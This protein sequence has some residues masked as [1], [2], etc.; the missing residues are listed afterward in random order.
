MK[1]AIIALLLLFTLYA[2]MSLSRASVPSD[3]PVASA[4][5]SHEPCASLV[6]SAHPTSQKSA[7]PGL[8]FITVPASGSHA[9]PPALMKTGTAAASVPPEKSAAIRSRMLSLPLQF[10]ENRGQ[11]EA[12]Y[13]F[14]SR[15]HG[16]SVLLRSDEARIIFATSKGTLAAGLKFEGAN[17]KV[18]GVGL[19]PLPGKVNY[20]KGNDES[21]WLTAVPT[22]ARVKYEG[23]YQ[24]VDVV[25]YGNQRRLEYDFVVAAHA[26]PK[27]ICWNAKGVDA[28]KLS[29]EGNLIL[30]IGG[31]DMEI[32]KPVAYQT[33][34]GTRKP[35]EA[36]YQIS[37][38]Q[39][40]FALNSY[41]SNKE[42]VIDPIVQF[43]YSTFLGGQ[44][45]D[46][47]S[48]V[49]VDAQGRVYVAG[50]SMGSGAYPVFGG[51]SSGSFPIPNFKPPYVANVRNDG[52]IFATGT[53]NGTMHAADYGSKDAFVAILS[54]DL[55]SILYATYLGGDYFD[56]AT[57]LV[58]DG[59]GAMYV[60]G[61]TTSWN[62]PIRKAGPSLDPNLPAA[63]STIK[64]IIWGTTA[65]TGTNI[66]PMLDTSSGLQDGFVT[67]LLPTGVL[68]FSTFIGADLD[69]RVETIC[70]SDGAV[71]VAGT[72]L[73]P[74]FYGHTVLQPGSDQ[75]MFHLIVKK[76]VTKADGSVDVVTETTAAIAETEPAI[77]CVTMPGA[78]NALNIVNSVGYFTCDVTPK[79]P[80]TNAYQREYDLTVILNDATG[81]K[82]SLIGG[83]TVG[84]FPS[85]GV[86]VDVYAVSDYILI[87][88][89][90][91][92]VN[93][94]LPPYI[95]INNVDY[96]VN[97][98][99]VVLPNLA[100]TEWDG[101]AAVIRAGTYYESLGNVSVMETETYTAD[102]DG[103]SVNVQG[104]TY[105]VVSGSNT[106]GDTIYTVAIGT[107]VYN[108][109]PT[110]GSSP[111]VGTFQLSQPVKFPVYTASIEY[112]GSTE[113][114]K[115][116][117][118]VINGQGYQSYRVQIRL[119]SGVTDAF[120]LRVDQPTL[121][122][123]N[124]SINTADS[125]I[126]GGAGDDTIYSMAA[127]NSGVAFAGRSQDPTL[128]G[129]VASQFYYPMI[130]RVGGGQALLAVL[131]NAEGQATA[132]AMDRKFGGTYFA[133]TTPSQK[134][135]V[136]NPLQTYPQ[137]L[138]RSAPN[139]PSGSAYNGFVLK[140]DESVTNIS[141]STYLGGSK[142]DFVHGLA[143][144][145]AGYVYV[146]GETESIDFPTLGTALQPDGQAV[147]VSGT[148]AQMSSDRNHGNAFLSVLVP[149]GN[150][151]RY[152]TYFGG[153]ETEWGFGVAVSP[154]RNP[155][156]YVVGYTNSDDFPILSGS[157]APVISGTN[158]SQTYTTGF[159]T[160]FQDQ[161]V[162][163]KLDSITTDLPV[164]IAGQR[165]TYTVT[166]SNT[167]PTI[168]GQTA[169]T[170]D[171]QDARVSQ[172]L[173][174]NLV[175]VS[176][177]GANIDNFS[178]GSLDTTT[179]TVS[180]D[181]GPVL[182]GRQVSY[183]ITVL[184]TS[185]EVISTA[186]RVQAEYDVNSKNDAMSLQLIARPALSLSVPQ[187]VGSQNGTPAVFMV[188]RQGD[189]SQTLTVNYAVA[190]DAANGINYQKLPGTVATASGTTAT[191]VLP[192]GSA[193][194]S[195]VIAPYANIATTG[196][197]KVILTLLNGV[198]YELGSVM[199]G[200]A[201]SGTATILPVDPDKVKLTVPDP[202]A[203]KNSGE[204]A[205]FTVLRTG[206]LGQ[207][208]T[209]WY[210]LAGSAII[211]KDY[212]IIGDNGLPI[213]GTSGS[214]TIPANTTQ[215][216]ISI[217]PIPD[218]VSGQPLGNTTVTLVLSAT[219]TTPSVPPP[220]AYVLDLSGST[221][222]SA[223]ITD[224][225]PD[226]VDLAVIRSNASASGTSGIFRITRTG[227]ASNL[228]SAIAVHYTM[229][230]TAVSGSD[231]VALTGVATIPA[232]AASVDVEV[233]PI[234][235]P[236]ETADE[237]AIMVLSP[238]LNQ[239]VYTL[240][241][242]TTGTVTI[243]HFPGAVVTVTAPPQVPAIAADI[244]TTSGT[245][246]ISRSGST[247]AP[248]TVNY[249]MGGTANSGV[250]YV[251]SSGSATL[252]GTV[253][254]P[255][256]QANATVTL[257]PLRNGLSSG[258]E[259]AVLTVQPASA[260]EYL[261][262]SPSNAQVTINNG[263]G[264]VRPVVSLIAISND[265][266]LTSGS[267]VLV[268]RVTRTSGTSQAVSVNYNI[269]GS[270]VNGSD[271]QFLTGAVA[272]GANV[273]SADVVV[274]PI[275][276][277][278][279]QP[280]K[281][282]SIQ[283]AAG[284]G[285]DLGTATYGSG[286][287]DFPDKPE[288]SL[289]VLSST[290][291]NTSASGTDAV[292]FKITRTG[293]S[294]LP[295]AINYTMGGTAIAGDDYLALPGSITLPA[296][297]SSGTV[298]VIPN[299]LNSVKPAKLVS[300]QLT[301]GVGYALG[302]NIY[303]AGTINFPND[304]VV[305]LSIQ[306][307]VAS[308]TGTN[309]LAFQITRSGD[310]TKG[311][312]VNYL[313]GGNAVAG[314]DY[315]ALPGYVVLSP[316]VAT[317]GVVVLPTWNSNL[318]QSKLM[319]LQLTT[320]DGYVLGSN[321]YGA[322]TILLSASSN[323]SLSVGTNAA[324]SGSGA[325]VF[326]VT[327]T[328]DTTSAVVVNYS[329]SDSSG[330]GSGVDYQP[331]SGS[332]ALGVGG[333]SADIVITP[334][335]NGTVRPDRV[336]TVQ[337]L[338]GS[339][340]SLVG[341]TAGSGTISDTAW[342]VVNLSLLQSSLNETGPAAAVFRVARSGSANLARAITVN[343]NVGGTAVPGI[344]Y[345]A[346]SGSVVIPV[347]ATSAEI[348]ITPQS[349]HVNTP[350]LSLIVSLANGQY[351]TAGS[352]VSATTTIVNVPDNSLV[353][354]STSGTT[355]LP[356]TS[357]SSI[358][359]HVTRTGNTTAAI[360]VYYTVGGSAVNGVDFQQ[361]SGAIAIPANET[362]ADIKVTPI[363]TGATKLAQIVTVQLATGVGYDLAGSTFGSGTITYWPW[364]TVSIATTQPYASESG[365][366]AVFQVTRTGD[367]TQPI[368]VNYAVAGTAV[369]GVNY[370][371]PGLNNTTLKGSVTIAAGGSSAYIVA[372]PV[373]D[374]VNT[375]DL[376]IL[377]ALTSG[378]Y[379]NVAG[380][381]VSGPNFNLAT[382]PSAVVSA[383]A[384]A[385]I[386]NV[387]DN[388]VTL[389]AIANATES[390]RLGGFVVNRAGSVATKLVV[391]YTVGGSAVAGLDYMAL[392]GSVVIPAGS[393]SAV[394]VVN[395][396]VNQ[397][398][399]ASPTV[400]LQLAPSINYTLGSPTADSISIVNYTGVVVW[401]VATK[402]T[403]T[404]TGRAGS[405][406][407]YRTGANVRALLVRYSMAGT[408]R[409]GY[410]YQKL[411]GKVVIPAHKNY[412][413]VKLSPLNRN[414]SA[415][416]R[417]AYLVL[418]PLF[419]NYL[420]GPPAYAKVD[421]SSAGPTTVGVKAD[422]V[423]SSQFEGYGSVRATFY[424]TGNLSKPLT[425][426]YATGG[427]AK[428]GVNFRTPHGSVII[429]GGVTSASVDFVT[430][431][432]HV[433]T[434]DLPMVVMVKPGIGYRIDSTASQVT[435][436]IKDADLH[437]P[438]F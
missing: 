69:T 325:L 404:N 403:A 385:T 92:Y 113:P 240:G 11:A 349:D 280:A 336:I 410:D 114:V 309:Y 343:Y 298:T 348:T 237:T 327:R 313:A 94:G 323:V 192:A 99:A 317:A 215:A 322:G 28:L 10:E 2:W 244:G 162:D 352:S 191:A 73:S 214:L 100:F 37:G 158:V 127:L 157:S 213:T 187:P 91:H 153:A 234:L 195:I 178:G 324:T 47:V 21:K 150:A 269:G 95:R 81:P 262:G 405:Y 308:Q 382:L 146:T 387:P 177:Q 155:K 391:N 71:R 357:G 52:S 278:T 370:T 44:D 65:L 110:L 289:T 274:T 12:E 128:T 151:L 39:I 166:V 43:I 435:L 229:E 140:S 221:S 341:N 430:V 189:L 30:T 152:S 63:Q 120:I 379:Y 26:D 242:S 82:F 103:L 264:L 136:F 22:N 372:T 384:G 367:V 390:G 284:T 362:S 198:N 25:Y 182:A 347:S 15:G 123:T 137:T 5:S 38:K 270:G 426:H 194:S 291:S 380:T 433:V 355:T 356:N 35:V 58:L 420:V 321:S 235:N 285:Y 364:D 397:F 111:L 161:T 54:S 306:N 225:L 102:L 219:S 51:T 272:L 251:L 139:D 164:P 407:I 253:T 275:W 326:H 3:K 101:G 132:V 156:A 354:L 299:W 318:Q 129:V 188:S 401:A 415:G 297:I 293:S 366:P 254:I 263:G 18:K 56:E 163:L 148:G 243:A 144:D 131:I 8:P 267:G 339:G 396:L 72:M 181:L 68:D 218:S 277:N 143:V 208:L 422:T 9:V 180:V 232:G 201:V 138:D 350:D 112:N 417:S 124:A 331:V 250:D 294:N 109:A 80:T 160:T 90:R 175:F 50:W 320:G 53:Y 424:R 226:Q 115:N 330:G 268:F 147:Q 116:N 388:L 427:S 46:S 296:G 29:K 217:V 70:L 333:S 125:Y 386:S 421:I 23:V 392:S 117:I 329:V 36:S 259:S 393:G 6:P 319:S 85:V 418:T 266:S 186:A 145:Q 49:A 93:S 238:P 183:T 40:R 228:A 57:G 434:P 425:V 66:V 258:S 381:T 33:E 89:V 17:P 193:T 118:A 45:G 247:M 122:N 227:D 432:D 165:M 371:V 83:T 59:S 13:D 209:V 172:T 174:S 412:V 363:W 84:I 252:S 106:K 287:I 168:V 224:V 408:T 353:S 314:S 399:Q 261:V 119:G 87:D 241:S 255:A 282:V 389:A 416:V 419:G 104:T 1:R 265:A 126:F 279:V 141:Y 62:F 199:T 344:N 398:S 133:G 14:L 409:N 431:D 368:T 246:T 134:F 61:N 307:A 60:C 302:P 365:V 290:A 295:I 130:G 108:V 202:Q 436:T 283:L 378:T 304:P 361:L 429:P 32:K 167:T 179:N 31:R 413:D 212:N 257:T 406:R 16:C 154:Y 222:G 169:A 171:C 377:I 437:G 337:L 88:H 310:L 402:P 142:N 75:G 34:N 20:Y 359:F 300:I 273:T 96:P 303:G 233:K 428:A 301:A 312:L 395:P 328:G 375:P 42:L 74:Y 288:V 345:L 231:Y 159:V 204:P 135:P 338:P 97:K 315:Q 203:S 305:N 86:A 207:A 196:T 239:K 245:F 342:D 316:S 107:S 77:Q 311:I 351:Y 334:I 394:V 260:G 360:L 41:D 286:T 170:V 374:H 105:P 373:N 276:S 340:Y 200:T 271:Y 176:A 190:G 67:K 48:S 335:W 414:Q 281:V 185:P 76:L 256:G 206:E 19:E 400:A 79:D 346:L 184:V 248:L 205:T 411:S 216:N 383:T 210:N 121:T 423:T 292:V 358:V 438:T 332:I 24:G 230:G 64:P 236:Q 369:P 4:S 376:S 220:V 149:A 7:T 78:L 197:Q 211:G 98:S 173:S 27:A 249:S 223:T 55:S